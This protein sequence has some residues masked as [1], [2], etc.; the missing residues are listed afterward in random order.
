MLRVLI[1]GAAVLGLTA[2]S[3]AGEPEKKIDLSVLYIGN[4]STPRGREYADFL[5]KHFRKVEATERKSF[6]PVRAQ[7]FDVVLLDW[8]QAERPDKPTS[9]L[10]PK[11]RWNKPAVLLG[12]AGLLLAQA[13]ETVGAI[14]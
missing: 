6:D 11:D 12:S 1:A 14:G 5:G 3:A 4:P 9:P 13:W 8:S 10:G 7:P 2:V